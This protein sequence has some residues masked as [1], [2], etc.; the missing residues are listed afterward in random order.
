MSKKLTQSYVNEYI[1]KY[2]WK[3]LS[4]YKDVKT[5][6]S[7]VCP[8][9]HQIE[10]SF[11]GF[12]QGKR[13]KRCLGINTYTY[14][15]VVDIFFKELYTLISKKYKDTTSKLDY[16]C[17]NGHVG[18]IILSSFLRGTRCN[19][20]QNVNR[21][22][23]Q[24]KYNDDFIKEHL[25]K[26]GDVLGS[27]YYNVDTSLDITCKNNH[28]YKMT[29]YKYYHRGQRCNT[30]YRENN[31]G[32]KHPRYN[33]DRTR[34]IRAS[35]LSFDLNKLHTLSDDP[36]YTSYIHSQK[37]AKQSDNIHARSEYSVDHIQPR[38]AFID[39]NLDNIYGDTIIKNICNL[40]ENLRIISQKENR[41]KWSSY[42]Q[43]EFMSWFNNK[44]TEL[45]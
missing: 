11:N 36:L 6:L 45:R 15:M 25:S 4:E 14:E 31:Y 1:S 26:N 35:Y 9:D 10:M 13:C 40:R 7:L 33:K 22:I 29:F 2:N 37:Q 41:D 30:C 44:L 5:K 38:I 21:S 27:K 8:N 32:Y 16:I 19:L 39:N 3:N 18:S 34:L 42:N 23:K 12:Q 28:K 20:C 24:R 43:E 17:P